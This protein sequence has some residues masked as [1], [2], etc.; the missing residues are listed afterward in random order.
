MVFVGFGIALVAAYYWL[1]CN[2]FVPLVVL[3]VLTVCLSG[4]GTFSWLGFFELASFCYG[5][6][7]LRFFIRGFAADI[8]EEMAGRTFW[9]YLIDTFVSMGD[10]PSKKQPTMAPHR[11]PQ[12]ATVLMIEHQAQG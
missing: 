11:Q 2:W 12:P 4:W 6:I 1:K 9:R 10:L 5:P 8:R 3:V 7:I